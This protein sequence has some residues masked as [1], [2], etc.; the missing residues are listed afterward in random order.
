MIA[1]MPSAWMFRMT[2]HM[3]FVKRAPL[4]HYDEPGVLPCV[5]P[6]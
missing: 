4:S 2:S 5:V 1:M 6:S 3:R